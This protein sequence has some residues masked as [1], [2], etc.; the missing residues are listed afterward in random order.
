MAR[1][2]YIKKIALQPAD[3]Q[4]TLTAGVSLDHIFSIG[5]ALLGGLLWNSFGYQYVFLMGAVFAV[6]NF[7]TALRIRFPH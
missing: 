2:T 5:A 3:I 1:N 6:I 7:F 4:T